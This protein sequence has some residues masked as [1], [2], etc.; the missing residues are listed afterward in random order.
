MLG[1][2][3]RYY[4]QKKGMSQEEL[5][6]RLHVVRQTVS[7]WENGVSVPDAD[8]LVRISELVDA[9]VSRLLEL[10]EGAEAAPVSIAEET[11]CTPDG[12]D[13]ERLCRRKADRQRECILFLSFLSLLFLLMVRNGVLAMVLTGICVFA[14]AVMLYRNPSLPAS[15]TA[16]G[17]R[18]GILRMTTVFDLVIFAAGM[19]VSLLTGLGVIS[20]SEDHQQ[21]FAMSAVSCV[22]LF[23]GFVSPRLPFTRHTGLRL[24]WTVQ[25]EDTWKTAH[26]I[27]GLISFPL[28]PFYMA[29]AAYTGEFE[30]VTLCVMLMWIGIPG[31]LSL[32]C[33][34]R[35]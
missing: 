25:D 17:R 11:V 32:L 14:A 10:E 26:R 3:I 18:I 30:T 8:V 13:R 15:G 27:L 19:T 12:D 20:L 34:C 4:R 6:V 21:M 33:F 16:D 5:A 22:I 24:P 28:V 29:A 31:V 7:K 9:P 2:R 1:E 23:G 35:K